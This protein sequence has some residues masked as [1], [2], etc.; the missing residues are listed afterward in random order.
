MVKL[1]TKTLALIEKTIEADQGASFRQALEKVI[2]KMED[3]Y[4]G[5]EDAF[6]SHMGASSIG[7]ECSRMLWYNFH[8]AV[9]VKFPARIMRLFNRGHL[10]EARFIAMLQCC[11]LTVHYETEDGGQFKMTDHGGHFG[12]ALDGVIEGIPDIPKGKPC[13]GEYKTSSAKYFKKMVANGVEAEKYEHYIQMQEYMAYYELEYALYLVVNKDDDDLYG[14][15]VKLKPKIAKQYSDRAKGL[16]QYDAPPPR[17]NKSP[18]FFKCTFCD[19]K[20]LCQLGSVMPV[21][22]CRTCAHSTPKMDDPSIH[23]KWVCEKWQTVIDKPRQ[24]EGCESHV[25]NYTLFDCKDRY[26]VAFKQGD[27]ENVLYE[28]EDGRIIVNGS[29]GI[30]SQDLI[31]KG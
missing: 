12:S 26:G 2:P 31:F 30:A 22:N 23:Q 5:K 9:P 3:A 4:R 28:H 1:A 27:G 21:V 25:F 16:I 6:R 20:A 15:I 29:G 14:E 19:Y 17:I 7:K 10:E 18:G 24:L 11:G 13:L 8:W